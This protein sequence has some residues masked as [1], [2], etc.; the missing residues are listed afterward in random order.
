[1]L[2][3]RDYI[4]NRVNGLEHVFKFHHLEA[5]PHADRAG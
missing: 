1:M 3:E 5:M 2:W 4:L